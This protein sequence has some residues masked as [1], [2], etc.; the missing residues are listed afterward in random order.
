MTSALH[1]ALLNFLIYVKPSKGHT[2]KNSHKSVWGPYNHFSC[3][4]SYLRKEGIKPVHFHCVS[5]GNFNTNPHAH[6]FHAL[7]NI[8]WIWGDKEGGLVELYSLS[9]S[10]HPLSLSEAEVLTQD[11]VRLRQMKE[12]DPFPRT[13]TC[14][15]RSTK[16]RPP[17]AAWVWASPKMIYECFTTFVWISSFTI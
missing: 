14:W 3:C 6:T 11:T 10:R 17:L 4:G 12:T 5:H 13:N 8:Y 7:L 1:T 2:H 9:L 16:S 15:D